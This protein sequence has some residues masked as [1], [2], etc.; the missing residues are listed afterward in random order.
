[1]RLERSSEVL[2]K[3]VADE[4]SNY[5][6]DLTSGLWFSRTYRDMVSSEV[7]GLQPETLHL[8]S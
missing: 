6:I 2:E 8:R 3:N 1:M 4:P 7:L 5:L